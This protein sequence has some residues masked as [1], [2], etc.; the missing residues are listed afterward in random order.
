MITLYGIPNCDTVKKARTWLTQQG[1]D[2][3]FHDF[4]KQGIDETTLRTWIASI[5]LDKLVNRA[6]TTWRALDDADKAL[7]A[8]P[9]SAIALLQAKPSLIKRPVL[10]NAGKLRVGFKDA[11]YT[12]EF[13]L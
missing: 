1:L 5:G 13:G 3:T 2:F 4:K 9:D 7:A 12:A 6:G 10:N 8:N 11:D